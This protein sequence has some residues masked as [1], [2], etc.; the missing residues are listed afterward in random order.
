M[1]KDRATAP[2][3]DMENTRAN[4]QGGGVNMNGRPL[5]G[6]LAEQIRALCFVK[7]ELELYLDTQP[8]CP[9]ALDYYSQTIREL[10]RL[11]EEYKNT[12][13]ALTAA[14][15]ITADGWTWATTPWPWQQAGDFMRGEK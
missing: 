2:R 10:N 5:S 9:T 12:V 11:N 3:N 7:N 8:A 13:G 1:N 15:V 6:S 4:R 14:D